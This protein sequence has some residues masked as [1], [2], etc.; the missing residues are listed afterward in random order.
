VKRSGPFDVIYEDLPVLV[1][2][3]W[4]HVT[5]ELLEETRAKWKDKEFPALEKLSWRYWI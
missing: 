5:L 4:E 1:V 3:R 2:D